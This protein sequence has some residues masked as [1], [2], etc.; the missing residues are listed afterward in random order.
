VEAYEEVKYEPSVMVDRLAPGVSLAAAQ[1]E[2]GDIIVFQRQ[3]SQV[4]GCGWWVGCP[5]SPPPLLR[6]LGVCL[7]AQMVEVLA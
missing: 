1:L 6:S 7:V 4:R 2:H 3:L 5:C